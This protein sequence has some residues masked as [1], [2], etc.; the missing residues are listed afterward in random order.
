LKKEL[1]L[2]NV[3]SLFD[4]ISAGHLALNRSNIS[5][6]NYY[7]SEIDKHALKVSNYHFPS[8]INLGDVTNWKEWDIDW[9][10]IDLLIGGSPCQGFSFAG[11]QLAFDDPRSKLFFVFVDILNHI[12]SVNPNVKFMLE[13]VK[14]KKEY[15][16]IISNHLNVQ[17]IIIN[18]R[19]VSAQNRVRYYWCNWNV[20]ELEDK[21]ISL[22][23]ALYYR[24]SDDVICGAYRGRYLVDGVRQDGKMKTAG[25]TTQR[26]ELRTDDKTNCITTVQKDNVLVV[27]GVARNF[28]I[29]EYAVLQTFPKYWCNSISKTQALKAYGNS[30]TVDVITHLFRNI[31]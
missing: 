13:N 8:D 7:K 1:F 12:K 16:D 28:T 26:L 29:E 22:K 24:P 23:Q 27:N 3:L 11:K 5:I 14:M 9:S 2:N 20:P 17:P 18:S 19:L 15:I 4:G 6:N 10:S 25:L 21:N 30:W 31:Q